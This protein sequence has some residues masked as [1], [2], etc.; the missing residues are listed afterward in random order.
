MA[1][2]PRSINALDNDLVQI[3]ILRAR[4]KENDTVDRILDGIQER[5]STEKEE[6]TKRQITAKN[7]ARL[8]ELDSIISEVDMLLNENEL[9]LEL[10]DELIDERD[11]YK[12]IR[13][14]TKEGSNV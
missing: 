1:R 5:F 6:A 12:I 13:K 14:Q 7:Q 10:R 4:N 8:R 2:H 11:H 3:R 9:S